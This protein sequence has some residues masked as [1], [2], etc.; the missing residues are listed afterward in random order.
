MFDLF[1][2]IGQTLS[3]NKLRMV[4]TGFAVAW[5][6][7][8]L[9]ILLSLA[10][11]LVHSF[12]SNM[13]SRDSNSMTVW[14]GF[15]SMPWR[16][17]S[18]G[19]SIE[20]KDHDIRHVAE[21][22]GNRIATVT[23]S[24]SNDTIRFTTSSEKS[25]AGYEGVFPERFEQ[26]P[27]NMIGGRV[28][29]ELDQM[30]E[31]KV[32]MLGRRNAELLFGNAADAVGKRVSAAGLSWT[33]IG[34]YDHRWRT[35]SYIPYNTALALNGHTGDVNSL[36]VEVSGIKTEDE[37]TDI[38][39]TVRAT[40]ARLHEFDPLDQSAVWV[41]NRFNDRL[42][43][44]NA[45]SILVYAMWAIGILTLLSG[46]VGVSNIMFVSVKERTHEIGVRRAIGAKRSDILRQIVLESVS[47]TTIFGYTG[48]VLGTFVMGI[49]SKMIG[50]S[51][52]MLQNPSIDLSIAFEVTAVLIVAGA[53]AG[54]F[55]AMKA[56]KIRPVEAL[57]DE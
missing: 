33:V 2:E 39:N 54:L 5:G 9:I 30:T 16:G 10:N 27:L 19:R 13:L 25:T 41:W 46:I 37:G 55:P 12:E 20:L 50:N 36:T 8:M 4:L 11:G 26:E 15:T 42:S 28:I 22:G 52:E 21:D 40:L 57:R 49:I 48:I 51:L 6:I 32:V 23:A 44:Q 47:I 14:G 1:R 56:T 31:R 35:E 18:D 53:F 34:V 3:H 29:N 45:M 38:E 17:Y 24:L 7:F 43:S